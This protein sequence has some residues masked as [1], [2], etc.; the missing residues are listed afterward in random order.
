MP[1]TALGLQCMSL[2]L[3]PFLAPFGHVGTSAVCPPMGKIAC[4][5]SAQLFALSQRL[6]KLA[7]FVDEELSQWTRRPFFQGHDAGWA[8]YSMNSNVQDFERQSAKPSH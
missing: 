1:D 7:N 6:R 8:W 5:K 2:F 3:A 4:D